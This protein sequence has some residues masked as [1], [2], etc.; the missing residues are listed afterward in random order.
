MVS[1]DPAVVW[2]S[3]QWGFGS[4]FWQ[5]RGCSL[6]ANL[7]LR[8]EIAES[9]V[10]FDSDAGLG[11]D[12]NWGCLCRLWSWFLVLF[13]RCSVLAVALREDD[14][15]WWFPCCRQRHLVLFNY[16]IEV[17]WMGGGGLF[18]TRIW[19]RNNLWTE[20]IKGGGWCWLGVEVGDFVVFVVGDFFWR[21]PILFG[22]IFVVAS[23]FFFFWVLGLI[24]CLGCVSFRGESFPFW[25][26][27]CLHH[28]LSFVLL[29]VRCI[30][31]SR[32]ILL[33]DRELVSRCNLVWLA[34]VFL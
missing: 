8:L 26:D 34:M 9:P 13:L 29:F 27:C 30:P 15:S 4:V 2:C 1:A 21:S 18:W 24:R 17:V 31:M 11:S 33:R 25:F 23:F 10:S 7:M 12:P 19:C 20:D 32:L 5:F 16:N 6:A 28:L 22:F 14:A 3:L